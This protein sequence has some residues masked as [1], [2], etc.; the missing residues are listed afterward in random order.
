VATAPPDEVPPAPDTASA[1][2][3][4]PL[5]VGLLGLVA[6]ASAIGRFIVS[7][8]LW[9]DEALSVNIARLPLGD[10][11]EALRQD[12]HPPLYY[13]LLHGW[14]ALVGEGDGAVRALSGIISLGTV[15]LAYLTGRRIGGHRLGLTLGLVFTVSPYVLR[16]GSET[17]MYALVMALVFVGYLLV[18]TTLE[19]PRPL[20]LVGVAL[21]TAA[22]L[23]THY[24]SMWFLATVGMLLTWRTWRSR[25]QDP[26][27]SRAAGRTLAAVV[28]G[29]LLFVPWLPSLA[30]Q[31]AHTGTPWAKAFRP[32]TLV[33]TSLTDFGGG[34]YGETQVL[35]I[36]LVLLA[37]LGATARTVD[38]RRLELDLAGRADA[39][40]PV[41]LLAGTSGIASMVGI[42]TG[43]AFHPRYAAVFFPFA[44]ILIALGIDRLGPGRVRDL[45]L[46]TFAVLTLVG[47]AVVFRLDR[48][49]SRVVADAIRRSTPAAL[50]VTCPDQLGPAVSR[51]L[52]GPGYEVV[53][54]PRLDSPLRVDWVD[55]A[56]RNR[57]NDPAAVAERLLERAGDRPIAVVF[58]DDYQTLQGQCSKLMEGLAAVRP[59]HL[60]VRAETADFYEA[61]TLTEFRAP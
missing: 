59:G 52:S 61:M 11:A 5:V 51:E 34:P 28:V 1:R 6:A 14:M 16:Y 32:A 15:P 17:R 22:L 35:A 7:S 36:L 58:G 40:V 18:D 53:A 27:A 56:D 23:W 38:D 25:R 30:Y 42:A 13:V 43:M 24:W 31:S 2:F 26:D 4:H 50:V 54:Y 46:A 19:R 47:L 57:R 55:Y 29:G 41:A 3:A 49:Q 33:I 60:L 12:G 39:R 8:P 21:V 44:A 48:S 9:L 10:L 37:F 45:V 20:P